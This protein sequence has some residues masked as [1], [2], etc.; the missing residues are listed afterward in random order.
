M[1][2][3]RYEGATYL[4]DRAAKVAYHP[5]AA[6]GARP[7]PAGRFQAGDL[8]P[9]AGDDVGVSA[10]PPG[11]GVTVEVPRDPVPFAGSATPLFA[12]PRLDL[13]DPALRPPPP[14]AARHGRR[15][16]RAAAPTASRRETAPV[17]SSSGGGEI[18][19]FAASA[20]TPTPS[21]PRPAPSR[22]AASTTSPRPSTP[23][24]RAMLNSQDMDAWQLHEERVGD[25]GVFL[26]DR[27]T[28]VAYHPLSHPGEWPRVAGVKQ[29]ADGAGG[30]GASSRL[31]ATPGPGERPNEDLF[32]R[33]DQ[34][35]RVRRKRLAD[36]FR[37][38][39]VDG[40]GALSAA[41]LNA[42]LL[43]VVPGVT[44][45]QERYFATMLGLGT[46][47]GDGDGTRS[48]RGSIGDTLAE[49]LTF[50]AFVDSIREARDAGLAVVAHRDD[51]V[52][53]ALAAL[54]AFMRANEVDAR[55]VFDAVDTDGSGRLDVEE[56]RLMVAQLNPSATPLE[57]KQLLAGLLSVDVKGRGSLGFRDLL[58]GL[59][60]LRVV[61][62]PMPEDREDREDQDRAARSDEDRKTPAAAS[63]SPRGKKT[64][65]P[66]R[67]DRPSSSASA[68][69]SSAGAPRTT[70]RA[71]SDAAPSP[72]KTRNKN[73][74]RPPRRGSPREW[75]LEDI[76]LGGEALM[77]DRHNGRVYA[78][79]DASAADGGWPRF[80]GELR[81]GALVRS[82]R[83]QEKRFVAGLD[84][85]LKS[86]RARL[87]D[88]FA[89]FDRDGT[90]TLDH[91]E[92]SDFVRAL[93]PDASP[94]DVAYFGA[95]LDVDCDGEVTYE[96][97]T[98]TIG[99]AVKAGAVVSA[100]ERGPSREL[101][102][103]LDVMRK[104]LAD[105]GFDLAE[106]FHRFDEDKNGFLTH[107]EIA[108]MTARLI[109]TLDAEELKH[110]VHHL[111]A[112]DADGDGRVTLAELY[113]CFRM[114]EIIRVK[115]E[116]EEKRRRKSGDASGDATDTKDVPTAKNEPTAATKRPPAKTAKPA[117]RGSA[118]AATA[119]KPPAAAK[120]SAKP[121]VKPSVVEP[122]AAK[123]KA[124]PPAK[125]A[126]PPP[127]KKAAPPP[128]KKA[129]PPPAKKA[130]PPPAKKAAPPP[131]KK[132][133]PPP[134]KKAAPP[135]AKK[136]APPPA[137][138]ASAAAASKP[139]T[140]A[141]KPKPSANAGGSASG[142]LPPVVAKK[143]GGPVYAPP[144]APA[145]RSPRPAGGD[146]SASEIDDEDIPYDDDFEEDEAPS[147]APSPP[148]RP[149]RAS[150]TRRS[151]E[152]RPRS[153]AAPS[154]TPRPTA[155]EPSE[156]RE[157]SGAPKDS[158]S[159]PDPDPRV[160]TLERVRDDG[161]GAFVLVDRADPSLAAYE[162]AE[163]G[164]WPTRVGVLRA[165]EDGAYVA[166]DEETGGARTN[167]SGDLFDELDAMLVRDRARLRDVFDAYDFDGDGALNAGELTRF[168]R[169]ALPDATDADARYFDVVLDVDGDGV[170]AFGELIQVVKKCREAGAAM[171][172]EV[173]GGEDS[174]GGLVRGGK[175]GKSGK[176]EDVLP[177]GGGF[178]PE[179]LLR[180]RRFMRKNKTDASTVFA[181]CDLDGSGFLEMRELRDMVAQLAPQASDHE[182]REMLAGLCVA[183]ER[184]ASEGGAPAGAVTEAQFLRALRVAEVRVVDAS[185]KEI[186]LGIE[187]VEAEAIE[188][189]LIATERDAAEAKARERD[190]AKPPAED[191]GHEWTLE[192]V[193]VA[194]ATFLLDPETR[195]L[196]RVPPA[197]DPSGSAAEDSTLAK[198]ERADRRVRHAWARERG[199]EASGEALSEALSSDTDS[200]ERSTASADERSASG[201]WPALVGRLTPAG[202]VAPHR[203][204]LDFFDALKFFCQSKRVALDR[205]F[206]TYGVLFGERS[207]SSK[208]S[209]GEK[210][211][212]LDAAAFARATR[213]CLLPATTAAELSYLFVL[214]D[215]DGD[216][217]VTQSDVE[218][219]VLE[220][221]ACG[222][223]VA[224][225]ATAPSPADAFWRVGSLVAA[226]HACSMTKFFASRKP[227][228]SWTGVE[229]LDARALLAMVRELYPKLDLADAR[230][231]LAA[232]RAAADI[233]GDGTVT[234][235]ELRRAVR[236][237][238][239]GKVVTGEG[240]GRPDPDAKPPTVFDELADPR[241]EA[242]GE[243]PGEEGETS[244][245]AAT[246]AT[247][248]TIEAAA[249]NERTKGPSEQKGPPT[250]T[251][252]A[253]ANPK[254]R[255]PRTRPEASDEPQAPSLGEH[256]DTP[257]GANAKRASARRTPP[258]AGSDPS[259]PLT[260]AESLARRKALRA[261]RVRAEKKLAR[262]DI[263]ASEVRDEIEKVDEVLRA[264]A[265][266]AALA[267]RR[268]LE[269]DAREEAAIVADATAF[270]AEQLE[271]FDRRREAEDD[272]LRA[273]AEEAARREAWYAKQ[274]QEAQRRA[275]EA[276]REIQVGVHGGH[277]DHNHAP[278]PGRDRAT[279]P[280]Y[281]GRDLATTQ[282]VT[283][284][285]DLYAKW[286]A[287]EL[288]AMVE[289]HGRAE[290]LDALAKLR[291]DATGA[292]A[293][294]AVRSPSLAR[295]VDPEDEA[296]VLELIEHVKTRSRVAAERR[297]EDARFA[298][299]AAAM[300]EAEAERLASLPE[301]TERERGERVEAE[302][303]AD[304]QLE[305]LRQD[306]V[307]NAFTPEATKTKTKTE[308]R[309]GTGGER[310]E[311]DAPGTPERAAGTSLYGAFAGYPGPQPTI[312]RSPRAF[313][314]DGER[315]LAVE[316]R[317][318][319]RLER[320]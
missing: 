92:A 226:K 130:A 300:V 93:V 247:P 110:V 19:Y 98:R 282:S 157:S 254:A 162:C 29:R 262:G 156:S 77:L 100:P 116:E 122:A 40:D 198:A 15:A 178:F 4:L 216:G 230:C 278:P 184:E 108:K 241:V 11:A 28:D 187:D 318:F 311:E 140:A 252:S 105:F 203:P 180:L 62:V 219:C 220:C 204:M 149:A 212:A 73:Q 179:A 121:N 148:P 61:V 112:M 114:S 170:V 260:R 271:R 51:E 201:G 26:V 303:D 307:P 9:F 104:Y 22:A 94:G 127:A 287:E 276:L 183:L 188:R 102:A 316:D 41:E 80:L 253:A 221:A 223:D 268:A 240:F 270:R 189:G 133:A 237:A 152:P 169:A 76:V 58:R 141:S 309:E 120:R 182:R 308:T 272:V 131:A 63:G 313:R 232:M 297:E 111:R 66:G 163:E 261:E 48:S 144:R 55:Q 49:R 39:D 174:S 239:T 151:A 13:D 147:A 10:P 310:S 137:K 228:R 50:D 206:E 185:G 7:T 159:D 196:F 265:Y 266:A 281:P 164:D 160:W 207:K 33:L 202:R 143:R 129:A 6:P 280:D 135:A 181:A 285:E 274:R 68:R 275:R 251:S 215:L 264:R 89:S 69:R 315:V 229:G 320:R 293:E 71:S 99:E 27:E 244:K 142:S 95:L 283:V 82:D 238:T 47:P 306:R 97:L 83:S 263:R 172:S 123:P 173:K 57:A 79:P 225:R 21:S 199:A 277:G 167:P 125:K 118:A 56:L 200:E 210:T 255:P 72:N 36:V 3:W 134:A 54:H 81:D 75:Y 64:L 119:K 136:A 288:L 146:A 299:E 301:E 217:R 259:P 101:L 197:S 44:P 195:Q 176:S 312:V 31:V 67:P 30:R 115:N 96:E 23:E 154:P 86:R 257:G 150:A 211:F 109:P 113:Q 17:P 289:T 145:N 12:S 302:Y 236:L 42:L 224:P 46:L 234:L 248:A 319:E 90:K 84:A 305:R 103:V 85:Y 45:S 194:G 250:K 117:A 214:L 161:T 290:T 34:F 138:K 295:T 304:L 43:D 168:V 258:L 60:L 53:P 14:P 158:G 246:Q 128:A 32:E 2:E 273:R 155:P 291:R 38:Y 5:P 218:R 256:G 107:P 186:V 106:A 227:S 165:D 16:G 213:E 193:S 124:P 298:A 25:A 65:S 296:R 24:R 317:S 233:T 52:P 292:F 249:A 243:E 175:P 59:R 231:V 192:A 279:Y 190:E 177:R 126:A 205:I 70:T 269:R 74:A 91:A 171:R 166:R 87:A 1:E 78:R 208:K 314:V 132:A 18:D 242:L 286:K 235:P 294:D 284:T 267:K 222:A 245:D 35:L 139:K 153:A 88:V 191:E 209:G 8:V 20:P 37:S